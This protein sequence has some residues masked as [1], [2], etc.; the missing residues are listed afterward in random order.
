ML[1]GVFICGIVIYTSLGSS[2]SNISRGYVVIID[3]INRQDNSACVKMA[4]RLEIRAAAS[5]SEHSP[6]LGTPKEAARYVTG[7]VLSAFCILCLNIKMYSRANG[8]QPNHRFDHRFWFLSSTSF[9]RT[10]IVKI[11]LLFC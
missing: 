8:N 5:T 6:Y 3:R 2:K 9:H 11:Q 10:S 7:Q 1:Q 4:F